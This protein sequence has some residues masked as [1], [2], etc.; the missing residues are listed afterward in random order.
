VSQAQWLTT[1]YTQPKPKRR[2]VIGKMV[3][4]HLIILGPF[5]SCQVKS[6]QVK[7]S[8]VK[9]S[10]VKSSQ[11]K[12]SQ[13]KSSQTCEDKAVDDVSDELAPLSDASS[14]NCR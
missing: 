8:Q 4:S 10:Q 9:S 14:H 11:V 13:V 12:S 6:S 5:I 2:G 7:S 1:G 3:N